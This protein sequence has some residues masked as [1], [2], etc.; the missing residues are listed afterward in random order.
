MILGLPTTAT[1][2]IRSCCADAA[3]SSPKGVSPCGFS[4][5]LLVIPSAPLLVTDSALR[6]LRDVLDNRTSDGERVPVF[7]ATPDQM[8]QIV[9]YDVHRGCLASG[10]R[11]ATLSLADVL[12][13]DSNARL[14]VVLETVGN[15]DNV[16][17]VFR[18]AA[19]FGADAVLL[20]PG[21]CDPLY[22]KVIRVSIGASLW[23][24]FAE[25]P[26]WPDGLAM[27]RERGFRIVAL[28]PDGD[29]TP[30]GDFI[31][32]SQPDRVALLVGAEGH[33]LSPH[34]KALADARVRIPMARGIDSLN[35]ATTAGIALHRFRD[36]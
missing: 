7:L 10:E 33:G 25:I 15:A 35:V 27:L 8:G 1:F 6:T 26:D 28:T 11:L 9:G 12:P 13:A 14:V 23:M 2:P 17:G 31:T 19:V 16:G 32:A 21:C 3:F 29:A 30:I 4:S 18:N 24:P 5:P 22:R 20:S 34:A 36:R